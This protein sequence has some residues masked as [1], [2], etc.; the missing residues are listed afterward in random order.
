ML[1]IIN[2]NSYIIAA[3]IVFIIA[4]GVVLVFWRRRAVAWLG[5]GTLAAI[6]IVVNLV[7]RVGVSEIETTAQFDQILASGRP[8]VLEIYSNY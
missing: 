1:Q 7:L 5:L 8:V 6:F 4:L 3:S 2:P